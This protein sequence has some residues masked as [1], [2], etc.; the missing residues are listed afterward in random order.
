MAANIY[1]VHVI[2]LVDKVPMLESDRKRAAAWLQQWTCGNNFK[3]LLSNTI[4][5]ATEVF[6]KEVAETVSRQDYPPGN[7]EF[8]ISVCPVKEEGGQLRFWRQPELGHLSA[9]SINAGGL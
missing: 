6:R 9:S 5:Q 8:D 2:R 3:G 7:F 4:Q 1:Y